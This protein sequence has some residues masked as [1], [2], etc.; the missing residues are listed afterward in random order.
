L[1]KP[2]Y[3]AATSGIKQGVQDITVLDKGPIGNGC[4]F[5]NAGLVVPS[6]II[7]LASP[8][9]IAKGIRWMLNPESPFFI[10]PRWD[11]ELAKWLWRFWRSA[12]P[13]HVRKSAPYLKD[14][15]TASQHLTRETTAELP[16][17]FEFQQNGLL[18]L[19]PFKINY[20]P[21]IPE[22]EEVCFFQKM[23]MYIPHVS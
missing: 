4:S 18:M 12:T 8:G 13:E 16:S 22:P 5:G 9:V 17:S 19:Y 23:P 3:H 20:S 1:N 14:L 6:H 2:G 15:L 10:R 21:Y 11:R 7:P